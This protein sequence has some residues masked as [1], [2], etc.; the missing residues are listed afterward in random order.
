MSPNEAQREIEKLSVDLERH[1]RLYYTE[2][3]P[4]ISDREY[5][6][7]FRSL[8]L[9]EADSRGLNVEHR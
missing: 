8:E 4:E 9:L 7:L 2:A 5:D 6:E 1:N 3:Q